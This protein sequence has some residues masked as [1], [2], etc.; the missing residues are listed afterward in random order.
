MSEFLSEYPF[1]LEIYMVFQKVLIRNSSLIIDWAGLL[2]N[3]KF[4]KMHKDGGHF[5]AWERP[6][7]L[8]ADMREFFGPVGGAAGVVNK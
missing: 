3:L 1:S 7:E 8:V 2:G 5:A 6:D 4:W